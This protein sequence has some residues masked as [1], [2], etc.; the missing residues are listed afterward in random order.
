MLVRSLMDIA[1]QHRRDAAGALQLQR[2]VRDVIMLPEQLAQR[3]L[4]LG[5]G[6]HRNV[7]RQNVHRERAQLLRDA[8][9]VQI[10]HA[11]HPRHRLHL[12]DHLLHVNVARGLLHQNVNRLLDDAP[13]VE[14]DQ[15]ADKDAGQR[16]EPVPAGEVDGDP[17]QHRPE[18]G[19]HIA[20]QMHEGALHIKIMLAA[21]VHHPGRQPIHHQG[22]QA[23]PHQDA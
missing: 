23:D 17:R 21:G 1:V 10:V 16:I 6:A 4:N 14:Q 8:P 20:H 15:H 19:Q 22:Q 3:R 11:A 7:I 2:G 18:R 9:D 5:S 13:G 12:R